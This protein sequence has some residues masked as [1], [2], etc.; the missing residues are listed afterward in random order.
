MHKFSLVKEK[1]RFPVKLFLNPAINCGCEITQVYLKWRGT[2][3]VSG[4]INSFDKPK[5]KVAFFVYNLL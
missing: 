5:F 4:D 1:L 2:G 3:T